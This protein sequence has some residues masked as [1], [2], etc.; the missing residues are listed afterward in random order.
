MSTASAVS[1]AWEETPW[2][3][4]GEEASGGAI[5][6]GRL[7]VAHL[8]L[9]RPHR[10]SAPDLVLRW[11]AMSSPA[12]IDVVIHLHGFSDS[13]GAMSLPREKEHRSGLDFVVD[14]TAGGRTRA[15]LGVLPRG[16]YYG[17]RS[18]AG[19][20]FPELVMPGR[21]DRLVE[22]SIAAFTAQTGVSAPRGRLIMTAHSGGGAPLM[23]ILRT[24]DPDEVHLFDAT[25]TDNDP[26]T[27]W[28]RHR[29]ERDTTGPADARSALR[30]VFRPHTGTQRFALWIAHHLRQ[31]LA[32]PGGPALAARY[33][34]EATG[35]EHMLIPGTFGGRL[36]ADAGADLPQ[37]L[38]GPLPEPEV[39]PRRA[40]RRASESESS[41]DLS[42]LTAGTDPLEERGTI[43]FEEFGDAEEPF[44]L[45]EAEQ[46]GDESFDQEGLTE[47]E[48]AAEAALAEESSR[49]GV[50]FPSGVTLAFGAGETGVG[51]THWDPAGPGLPLLD[52]GPAVQDQHV[53]TH[54]TVRE[55]VSSGGT[56]AP[57]AR[58]APEL[59]TALESVRLAVGRPVTVTSGYRS[60]A[61]N[62]AVYRSRGER[63]TKSRHSAGQAADI[64]VHGMSGMELA[65]RA[66]DAAGA[67]LA[68]GIGADFIHLD[69]RGEPATWTYFGVGTPRSVAA[70]AELAAYRAQGAGGRPGSAPPLSTPPVTARR[71]LHPAE[72]VARFGAD[73]RASEVESGVPALVTLGQ[74]AL[75]SGWGAHAPRFNFFG[76]KAKQ[77]EPAEGRQLLRTR[78]VLGTAHATGFPEVISVTPRADGRY[79]YV[80]RAWFRAY[81]DARAAF[82]DHGRFLRANRRYAHAFGLRDPFAFAQAVAAAG[83]ATEPNYGQV[84]SEVMRTIERADGP[85]RAESEAESQDSWPGGR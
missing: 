73:A 15:T 5:A 80:V 18:G 28:A 6:S 4:T 30:V 82:R 39:R 2:N 75:E 63:P 84:L 25:Y 33:R 60:Y 55:L 85:G 59:V 10:G 35:V 17:G 66:I 54:F 61:R 44:A 22:E 67:T 71:R 3:E 81:P 21:I 69:V 9:L 51:R 45:E 31:D 65:K 23:A 29:I 41:L 74:A 42:D 48:G 53:S 1:A 47:W 78:E 14:G 58:I 16:N 26:V 52:T 46:L 50:T 57:V 34:V 62:L 27:A 43:A 8:P 83:Y 32:R 24:L 79:D 11:N 38:P 7:E 12:A 64:R 19:Y 70:L 13:R 56:A 36:L 37:V 76:I 49:S 20:D 77:T 68:I 40:P 72:F